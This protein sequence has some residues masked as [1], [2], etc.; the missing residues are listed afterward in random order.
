MTCDD[1]DKSMSLHGNLLM[2]GHYLSN[3]GIQ[4]IPKNAKGP[5]LS[6]YSLHCGVSLNGFAKD[7]QVSH[8]KT[9][10]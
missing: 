9:K 3:S 8:S 6:S 10:L 7:G 2:I 1:S 5:Q 4:S